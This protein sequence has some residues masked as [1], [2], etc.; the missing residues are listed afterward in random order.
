MAALEDPL[1][2]LRFVIEAMFLGARSEA[3][4]RYAVVLSRGHLRVRRRI[5][6]PRSGSSAC[7]P[8]AR[9]RRGR[10]EGRT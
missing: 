8:S 4:V 6:R 2:R 10:E 1:E 3:G 9:T 7:A 5:P